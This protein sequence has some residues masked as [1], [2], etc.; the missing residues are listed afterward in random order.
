MQK[1]AIGVLVL[2]ILGLGAYFLLKPTSVV[3]TLDTDY[4]NIS[5]RIDNQDYLLKDGVSK[6]EAAP[7]SASITTVS[8]FGNEAWGDFN[9]DGMGDVAFILTKNDGG[10]GTFYYAAVALKT[11]TGYAGTNAVF[12]GDRIAPQTTEF[13]DGKII[14]NYADRKPGEPMTA[15]PS[16]GV[17]KYLKVE[18]GV[19][20]ESP[21]FE[22]GAASGIRGTVLLGPTCPVQKN[23]PDPQCADKPYAAKLVLTAKGG[24]SVLKEFSADQYGAFTLDLAPGTYTIKPSP[25][26]APLPRCQ[27]E[28]VTINQAT[29]TSVSISCDSGIR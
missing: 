2:A 24:T 3:I 21:P 10:S 23:P 4:K 14:V 5:Y 26:S 22:T 25:S 20:S 17:S 11:K 28:D 12:L 9:R 1:I 15:P 27:S 7:G 18:D 29:Y 8:Y 19:L 6:T 16:V 13:R